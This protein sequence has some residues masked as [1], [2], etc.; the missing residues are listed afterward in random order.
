M[1]G[2]L[3]VEGLNG[4]LSRLQLW[5]PGLTKAPLRAG[6]KTNV[7]IVPPCL[8]DVPILIVFLSFF[9]TLHG[10]NLLKK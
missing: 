1:E 8:D 6:L 2:P 5:L 10:Q 9:G 4:L 3:S 7:H